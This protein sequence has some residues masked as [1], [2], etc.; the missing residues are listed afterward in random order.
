MTFWSGVSCR[1]RSWLAGLF[2]VAAP[3]GCGAADEAGANGAAGE[4]AADDAGA[5]RM[6]ADGGDASGGGGG[7]GCALDG[8]WL[9]QHHTTNVALGAEQ[10]ATNWNYHRIEQ[11]GERFQI[12]ESLDCAYVVR[13]TTD[14]SVGEAT[15]E[16]MARHSTNAVGVEGSFA[17]TADGER[18]A[19]AFDRI[20]T[21]R[22]ANRERFLDAVWQIGDAPKPLDDFELP[23]SAE[24]GM[25]DW[26]QDG[27]EGLTQLTGF[28]DRYTAQ[29]D[30]HAFR[31]E[32]PKGATEFGGQGQLF[33]DYDARE[34]V[35][36]ETDALLSSSSVPM[37]PG[38]G[39]MARVDDTLEV[40][41]DGEHPERQTCENVQALAVELF[42]D[43]PRP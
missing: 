16:A 5:A 8:T 15:L 9:M 19:L 26:D 36:G 31:G 14:V 38:Y 30:W 21:V 13:G 17:P 22:G 40:V 27:H 4:S 2:V 7:A 18:C 43:P 24:E 28:G 32:V 29:I 23:G 12:V 6:G 39:F 20:Y 1:K 34:R 33:V 37:P 42:G 11:E 25:E 3:V 35:S 10:L 41:Q